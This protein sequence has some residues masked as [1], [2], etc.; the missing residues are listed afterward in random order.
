M[1]QEFVADFHIHS[2]FSRATS[3]SLDIAELDR[4]ASKKGVSVLG[5]GDFTHPSWIKELEHNLVLSSSEGM[6]EKKENSFGTKFIFTA[7][8]SSIY[9]KKGKVR[10]IHTLLFAPSLEAVKKINVK[11]DNLGN[12]KS[13]GRP[14]L[15][16]DV[17]DLAEL[18]LDVDE[19]CMIVPAHIWTPWFGLLGSKS[20]FDSLAEAYEDMTS[21]IFACETGLSSDPKMNWRVS[22]LDNI[23]LISNS[24]CHSSSKIAREGNVFLCEMSYGE[25]RDV[26]INKD[27]KRFLKTLEFFPEEGKYH[28][29]GHRDCKNRVNPLENKDSMCSVCGKEITKGVLSR[30]EELADR[31]YGYVPENSIPYVNIIPLEEILSSFLGFGVKTKKV[32]S[33]YDGIISDNKLGKIEELD[34]LLKKSIEDIAKISNKDIAQVIKNVREGYVI[35]DAGYDGE[36]GTIKIDNMIYE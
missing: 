4:V 16:L 5:T 24:D 27:K 36:F 10:R 19:R 32:Q 15:G 25:I 26:L 17:R 21:Y 3:K 31:D 9:S 2:R 18:V 12:I 14:I 6:Y 30:V 22:G 35:I 8:V 23:S 20:G 1:I 34:F 33:V 13:D 28:Y 29:S 11:L 7:E